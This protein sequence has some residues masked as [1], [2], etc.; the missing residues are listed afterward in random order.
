MQR[1]PTLLYF[2]TQA[3]RLVIYKKTNISNCS[4]T[5]NILPKQLYAAIS[6]LKCEET[7]ICTR[8]EASAPPLPTSL[9]SS[10][11][12]PHNSQG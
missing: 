4:L 11:P 1:I 6:K 8:G 7:D 5:Q 12:P 2:S 10:P 9:H 3:N